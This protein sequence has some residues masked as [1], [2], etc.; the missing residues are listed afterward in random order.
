MQLTMNPSHHILKCPGQFMCCSQHSLLSAGSLSGLWRACPSAE[1]DQEP[2]CMLTLLLPGSA[3]K[4]Q[5]H[6]VQ[7]RRH[8]SVFTSMAGPLG[9]SPGQTAGGLSLITILSRSGGPC[10]GPPSYRTHADQGKV[11]LLLPFLP[12]LP[13]TDL[14]S[15]GTF[16][17]SAH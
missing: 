9:S 5:P 16:V 8:S 7:S 11:S 1:S 6:W 2:Q 4:Q 15:L 17:F 13:Q 3:Q 12:V 10:T 14:L